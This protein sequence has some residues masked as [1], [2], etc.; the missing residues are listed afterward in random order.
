MFKKINRNKLKNFAGFCILAISIFGNVQAKFADI[1]VTHPFFHAIQSLQ[2]EGVIE[3]YIE[4]DGQRSFRSLQPVNRA[5]AVKILML[6]SKKEISNSRENTFPDVN[7]TDWFYNYVNTAAEDGIVK[8]FA[9]GSFHPGA[10]VTRAE[11]LKM[12][13][14]AFGVPET[15]FIATDEE[16]W[17]EPYF[18]FGKDL[19]IISG[20][21]KPHQSIN[22]GEVAE[23]I[24]RTQKVAKSEF[25]KKY[26][27]SGSGLASYYH[28]SLAGNP[29]A[30]GEVYDPTALTAAHRTLPFGT[31]LKVKYGDKFVIVRVNDRGPYHEDR[32]IDLSEK[33]FSQLAPISRGVLDVDFEVYTDPNDEKPAVPD[34]IRE[35]LSEEAQNPVVP[36]EVAKVVEKFRGISPEDEKKKLEN[37]TQVIFPDESVTVLTKNF[38]PNI[39]LRKNFPRK[40]L[41]GS[42]LNFSGRTLENGHKK[43]TV[44]LQEII[45]GKRKNKE[46]II[47]SGNISGKNFSFP[48][49][50]DKSGTFFIGVVL[51]DEK[52][53]RTETIEVVNK[54]DYRKFAGTKNVFLNDFDVRVLPEESTVFFDFKNTEPTDLQKIVFSQKGLK[55]KILYIYGGIKILPLPYDFFAGFEEFSNLSVDLF[56]AESKDGTL[57]TQISAWKKS[58]FKNFEIARAFPDNEDKRIN[59]ENFSRYYKELTKTSSRGNIFDYDL[60]L[61][62]EVYITLPNGKV[63]THEIRINGD[64]FS[65]DFTPR[66]WGR[67]VIEITSDQGEILFNRAI[68]FSRKIVIPILQEEA[69]QVTGETVPNVRFWINSIRKNAGKSTLMSDYKLNNF[70]QK[71]ADQMA[72]K[73]FISHTSPT[74]GTF[75]NRIKLAKLQGEF[76]ENLSYGTTLDLAL[77]GLKNSASHYK[78]M[79]SIRWRKVGVGIKKSRKGWYVAN[80]FGR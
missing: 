44:F 69:V 59:I 77:Q 16:Q 52:K 20:N 6:A 67:Y 12:T 80:L 21:D 47:Y 22:R 64:Q 51:D 42:V 71:Y 73:D 68:Y 78:N 17:F 11:M 56:S 46:Q 54:K 14:I 27:Y 35:N 37:K 8:G 63:I 1:D 61:H 2:D 41:M 36:E 53:S 7:N 72:E 18:R 23:I 33:A 40:Y 15:E 3:G 74:E 13:L 38:F 24:Y 75:A 76:G 25:T 39:K 66:D 43:V 4:S 49:V 58:S 5:E 34:F 50:L 19:R 26:T 45:N 9:D 48:V 31:R 70:A 32:I 30:N 62:P 55:Q 79:T 65:F 60:N 29:T 10:Q 28:S 57:D